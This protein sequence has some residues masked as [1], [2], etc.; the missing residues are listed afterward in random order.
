MLAQVT[1]SNLEAILTGYEITVGDISGEG[2][3]AT[4]KV[5]MKDKS[6]GDLYTGTVTATLTI[7]EFEDGNKLN[8]NQGN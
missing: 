2:D 1:K 8:G 7:K 6:K 5:L 4:R 3:S